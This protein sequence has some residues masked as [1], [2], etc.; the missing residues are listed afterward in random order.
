MLLNQEDRRKSKG[1][2]L[3]GDVRKRRKR[4]RREK[5]ETQDNP[6]G[7]DQG[8]SNVLGKGRL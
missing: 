1:V 7:E 5:E 3:L 2:K 4:R 8:G 6:E